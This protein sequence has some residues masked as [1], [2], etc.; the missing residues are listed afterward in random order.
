MVGSFCLKES[1][2]FWFCTV[3]VMFVGDAVS[4]LLS[5][6]VMYCTLDIDAVSVS[7]YGQAA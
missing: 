6:P 2:L 7:C 3:V 1:G 4:L 5:T